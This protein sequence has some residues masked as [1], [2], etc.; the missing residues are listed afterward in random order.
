MKFY[1]TDVDKLSTKYNVPREDILLIALNRYGIRAGIND[2]RI[3]F[4]IKLDSYADVF[5]MAICVNTYDT[6][7]E[8]VNNE[9]LFN[10][11]RIASIIDIEEDTCDSTYFRRSKT[12]LTLNSNMRSQCKGCKFC[13]TYKLDPADI[14]DLS[15]PNKLER[16]I[17]SILKSNNMQS[18]EDVVRITL[19]TGCFP[20]EKELV[21]HML[22]VNESFK[23]YGFSKRIRYIGSQLRSEEAMRIIK[24]NVNAFSLSVTT[25]R[26]SNRMEIMRKEK[27]EL[28]LSIIKDLLDRA[29][30]YEFSV[31]YL[32]ILGLE[33]L[34]E[35]EKGM[36]YLKD[37]INRFPGVQILQNFIP[38]HE[39][40]R[41]SEAK[42]V[43]Y[44]LQARKII[45]KIFCNE[46]YRPRSWENYRGLFYTQY[47]DMPFSCIR[48]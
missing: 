36:R 43:E 34:E 17:E 45:E 25:E 7:F 48:I 8:L 33:N 20:S 4:K 37:S 31:N 21:D 16:Y 5:Y 1:M 30:S 40:Y 39:N 38:E 44:Y 14:T 22:M 15:T 47:N 18:F 19:C 42:S 9:L 41:L 46:I 10:D 3:R 32:Y 13:G 27:A 35:M 2:N 6:P 24:E 29:K 23:K 28:D 12:E 26:F 11:E